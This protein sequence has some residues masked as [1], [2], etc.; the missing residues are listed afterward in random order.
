MRPGLAI[1]HVRLLASQS[2]DAR[3]AAEVVAADGAAAG[4]GAD[5]G[6]VLAVRGVATGA[7]V[8]EATGSCV[9][10]GDP[11]AAASLA[12]AAG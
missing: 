7:G 12:G 11:P 8:V 10:A 6:S 1:F 5:C 4:D 9:T 3:P 2:V